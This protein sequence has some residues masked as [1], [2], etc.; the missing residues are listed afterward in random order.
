ME[1]PTT[2]MRE[3]PRSIDLQASDVSGQKLANAKSVPAD[4]T[5]GELVQGLLVEMKLPRNDVAGRPLSYHAR[6]E[7]EGRHLH[8]SEVVGDALQE[9]DRIVLQPNIDAGRGAA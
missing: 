1:T 3:R 4:S 6:L 2:T 7:R 9:Q 8:A 5:V